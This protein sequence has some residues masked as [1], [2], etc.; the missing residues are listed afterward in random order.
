MAALV[1]CAALSAS[2]GSGEADL[3]VLFVG[4]SH[5]GVNDVPGTVEVI[6]GANGT[7][8]EATMIAPGG[9]RLSDH[10]FNPEVIDALE[11]GEFDVVVF[12]EQSQLPSVPQLAESQTLPAAL[13]LDAMADEAGTRVVW[14]QTW[15]HREG[16]PDGGHA[17]YPSMQDAVV[18][19][20]AE[21]GRQTGGDVAIAG[22]RWSRVF[23]GDPTIDL[24]DDDGVHASEIGSYLAAIAI[25]DAL[26]VGVPLTEAPGV[27]EVD[28]DLALR[29][30]TS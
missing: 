4:N 2:C 24:Y 27:G 18:E 1:A 14:F 8:I 21:I 25:T 15:A 17:A 7:S 5:T 6:A 12:Q 11:S 23:L 19:T 29:L 20:Y 16:W 30:L 28:D 13:A 3:Q 26:L 22:Q 10:R 9:T